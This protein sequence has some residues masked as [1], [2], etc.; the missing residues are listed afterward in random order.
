MKKFL[1]MTEIKAIELKI[2]KYVHEFCINNDI[3]YFINYGTLLGAVRHKGFIPWDDDIDIMMS[4]DDYNKFIDLFSKED[5]VYKVISME[6]N[7][8]YFNNF[9]KIIDS[10][11]KI[12]DE[13][14]YKTY[15]SGIFIDIFPYDTFYELK[16]VNKTYNWESFKLLSFS[17]KENIQY[18][19]SKIK[20]F[21]RLMFWI[22][23][24]PVSPRFFAKKIEKVI[25]QYTDKN[26]KYV[27]LLASKFKYN[28][29]F[30]KSTFEE[31]IELD[32][33]DTK[34]FAPKE[35]DKILTQYYGDY[36]KFPPIEKQKYPHEIKAYFK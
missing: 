16:V 21:I 12:E 14:N 7:E 2:L 3:K 17:K 32:F 8:K 11:T 29:V 6:T 25:K 4:R 19:D 30:E 27:A 31:L 35:Y 18:G 5:S 33:E 20:D 15:E 13:R 22:F 10:S 36:M 24:K 34:F 28:E 26:G 23:L 1:T 9:I